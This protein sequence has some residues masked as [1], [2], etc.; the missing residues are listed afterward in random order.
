MDY[1]ERKHPRLKEYD[2]ASCGAYFVTFCTKDHKHVLS[3]V[4]LRCKRSC[5]QS[6]R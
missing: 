3:T 5:V 4:A 6:N 1:P 2:Y